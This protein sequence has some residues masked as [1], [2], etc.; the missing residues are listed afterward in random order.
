MNTKYD[1][2]LPENF[3]G[4]LLYRKT[5]YLLDISYLLELT[6]HN[7]KIVGVEM[8]GYKEYKGEPFPFKKQLNA[9]KWN[10][11]FWIK[12]P[13]YVNCDDCNY[14]RLSIIEIKKPSDVV[15]SEDTIGIYV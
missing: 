7:G 12:S 5:E 1:M 9:E 3:S 8:D 14:K 4:K 13:L 15:P 2:E 10:S 6:F 11:S